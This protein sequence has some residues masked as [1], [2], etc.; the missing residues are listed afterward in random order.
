MGWSPIL[1]G[2]EEQRAWRALEL[3]V[4]ALR[5]PP[6]DGGEVSLARGEAGVALFFGYLARVTGRRDLV[7]LAQDRLGVAIDRVI[8]DP[9]HPFLFGGITGVAWV[10]EH[11]A[12]MGPDPGGDDPHEE[13]DRMI[14]ELLDNPLE[15]V[16]FE[17]VRGVAGFAVYALERLPRPSAAAALERVVDALAEMADPQSG[18][19]FTGPQ[20]MPTGGRARHPDGYVSLGVGHGMAGPIAVLAA[21]CAHGVGAARARPLALRALDALWAERRPGAGDGELSLPVLAGQSEPARPGWCHGDAGAGAALLAAPIDA[22]WRGRALDL[23]RRA[24]RQ[25]PS[26]DDPALSQGAAGLGHLFHRCHA[27]TGEPLFLTAARAWYG[28]A[29]DLLDPAAAR[30]G[31]LEGAGIGLALLAATT[32]IAPAWDRALLLSIR[33]P[34]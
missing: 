19:W 21:A 8:A 26:G 29:L 6:T 14:L 12:S 2:A 17:L 22:A 16:R 20:R 18:R 32:R 11:L 30:G 34:P 25:P 28:R 1:A 24:A 4:E 3:L 9:P 10:A 31:L 23:C 33:P 27:A 15:S 7:Q 5:E 13:I